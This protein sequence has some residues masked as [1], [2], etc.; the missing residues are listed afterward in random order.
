MVQGAFALRKHRL[1]RMRGDMNLMKMKFSKPIELESLIKVPS[2]GRSQGV[3]CVLI[4]R[5]RE[6]F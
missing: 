3:G 4:M 1:Q 2:P 6:S 5:E